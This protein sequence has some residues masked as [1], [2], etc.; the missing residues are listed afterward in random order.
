MDC[1]DIDRGIGEGAQLGLNLIVLH[2]KLCQLQMRG[3]DRRAI[4]YRADAAFDLASEPALL[5]RR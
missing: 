3:A 1:H 2:L 5:V 4:E